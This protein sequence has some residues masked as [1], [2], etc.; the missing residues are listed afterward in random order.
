MLEDQERRLRRANH[1][2]AE[3]CTQLEGKAV[4]HVLKERHAP[5]GS[6]TKPAH[7]A[8]CRKKP[9]Q[10]YARLRRTIC[11]HETSGPEGPPLG[12]KDH[13]PRSGPKT[14]QGLHHKLCL[15]VLLH[16]Q[17]FTENRI[18]HIVK[19][20]VG[21]QDSPALKDHVLRPTGGF[22]FCGVLRNTNI[23]DIKNSLGGWV[24]QAYSR[25]S[26]THGHITDCKLDS[27][28]YAGVCVLVN[29]DLSCLGRT[30]YAR[31]FLGAKP[32]IQFRHR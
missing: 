15:V 5:A 21:T 27:V 26:T 30:I 32:P 20:F 7:P 24:N 14:R 29:V 19:D 6:Q 25:L 23:P 8:Q 17:D 1:T 3:P 31:Q 16:I 22:M 11:P 9:T 12:P 13:S 10:H 2:K 18:L 28:V 4:P